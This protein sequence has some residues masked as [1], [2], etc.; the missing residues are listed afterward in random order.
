MNW[1]EKDQRSTDKA[2]IKLWNLEKWHFV[3]CSIT[4]QK[5][6]RKPDPETKALLRALEMS[7]QV[8]NKAGP[9]NRKSSKEKIREKKWEWREKI[10]FSLKPK[11]WEKAEVPLGESIAGGQAKGLELFEASSARGGVASTHHFHRQAV[12]LSCLLF[13]WIINH[14]LLLYSF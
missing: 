13:F 6:R 7:T 1:R 8:S 5:T 11:E 14:W 3:V 4:G 9:Q 2:S 12:K 10:N